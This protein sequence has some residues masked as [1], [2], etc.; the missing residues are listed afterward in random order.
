MG[1]NNYFLENDHFVDHHLECPYVNDHSFPSKVDSH[2]DDEDGPQK[3]RIFWESQKFLLQEILDQCNN[4]NSS[5]LREQIKR[6]IEVVRDSNF[7]RCTDKNL[8]GCN[9][10]LRQ[11]T[12]KHLC[13]KGFNAYLCTSKWKKTHKIP[14]GT[15]EYIEVVAYTQVRKKQVAFLVELGFGDEFRV[16]KACDEYHE[17]IGV[18][19]EIYVGKAEHLNAIVRVVCEAAKKSAEEKKIHMGPWR[20]RDFMLMKW[21]ASS[22][23]RRCLDYPT[24]DKL[25]TNPTVQ[26]SL[27]VVTST[28]G[29]A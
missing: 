19:P 21:S 24:S 1:R 16:A 4:S 14:G 15:H 28:V 3:H 9:K 18:L 5:N 11:A 13:S 23:R 22:G 6:H 29:L 10:C 17:L 20:K 25:R 2:D 26:N 7:C 27:N 12:I 8:R